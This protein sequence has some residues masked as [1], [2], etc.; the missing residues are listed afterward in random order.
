M[1]QIP[2]HPRMQRRGTGCIH[3]VLRL[4]GVPELTP[5]LIQTMAGSINPRWKAQFD[6]PTCVPCF[7]EKNIYQIVLIVTIIGFT[8]F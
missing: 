3:L 6:K 5:V 1:I 7:L 8:P 2:K 4:E